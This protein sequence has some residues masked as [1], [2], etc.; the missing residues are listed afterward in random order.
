M[1]AINDDETE[2]YDSEETSVAAKQVLH[3]MVEEKIWAD[4]HSVNY[5]YRFSNEAS[6]GEGSKDVERAVV[7]LPLITP[8]L[9][10]LTP[11]DE[12]EAHTVGAE[13]CED[14]VYYVSGDDSDGVVI[15][16]PSEL[17]VY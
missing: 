3:A 16:S 5:C 8:K 17:E 11:I 2:L 12:K 9:L 15:S 1:V 4:V 10:S 14:D 13:G 6:R 7:E